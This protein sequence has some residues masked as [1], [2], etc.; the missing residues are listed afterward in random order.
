MDGTNRPLH[1]IYRQLNE[2]ESPITL[3]YKRRKNL[4]WPEAD[5]LAMYKHGRGVEL[6]TTGK[7][8]QL[9][10]QRR[11]RTR[12]DRVAIQ[13][14]KQLGHAVSCRIIRRQHNTEF[15]Y[16]Y[17]PSYYNCLVSRRPSL[18]Y[19]RARGVVG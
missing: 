16:N 13:C 5:Q 18:L 2:L 7:Q 4:N 6:G 3:P 15:H 17:L 8:F 14:P 1:W 12:G 10:A 11:I 9:M 19:D